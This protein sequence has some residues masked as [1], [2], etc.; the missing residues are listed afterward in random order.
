MAQTAMPFSIPDGVMMWKVFLMHSKDVPE[1]TVAQ[2][3][4]VVFDSLWVNKC[5]V[6]G[7]WH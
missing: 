2:I 7:A 6:H 1:L 3:S 4:S 5:R